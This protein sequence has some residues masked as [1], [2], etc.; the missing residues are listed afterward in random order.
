MKRLLA[1]LLALAMLGTVP[2][3]AEEVPAVIEEEAPEPA[4]EEIELEL[5]D[6]EEIVEESDPLEAALAVDEEEPLLTV[7]GISYGASALQQSFMAV[8]G[9]GNKAYW[10]W[11]AKNWTLHLQGNYYTRRFDV[12]YA[13]DTIKLYL[14]N[15]CIVESLSAQDVE[16][17]GDGQI[18]GLGSVDVRN[19]RVTSG[20]FYDIN[21][22]N[23]DLMAMEPNWN[24]DYSGVPGM[25]FQS[26]TLE[27]AFM[28]CANPMIAERLTIADYDTGMYDYYYSLYVAG[29]L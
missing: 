14:T 27:R 2:A 11:D 5:G 21:C 18:N 19:M 23:I 10:T 4:L 24:G 1:A 17:G 13:G 20:Q 6:E 28:T 3:L 16:L 26:L 8:D 12:A 22:G 15:R 25:R 9:E 7:N 29:T